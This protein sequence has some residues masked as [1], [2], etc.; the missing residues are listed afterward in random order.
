MLFGRQTRTLH[1]AATR[2][3]QVIETWRLEEQP[4]QLLAGL[5][6]LTPGLHLMLLRM[7]E[8][9]RISIQ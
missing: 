8:T 2:P 5:H 9:D 3:V 7:P 1:I 4:E 6:A